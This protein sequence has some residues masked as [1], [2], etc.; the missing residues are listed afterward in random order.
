MPTNKC[1]NNTIWD[2][3]GKGAYLHDTDCRD[4]FCSGLRAFWETSPYRLKGRT[5]KGIYFN[6]LFGTGQGIKIPPNTFPVYQKYSQKE[7]VEEYAEKYGI[8]IVIKTYTPD[9]FYVFAT[10]KSADNEEHLWRRY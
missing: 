4:E 2:N 3:T 9:G 6:G 5:S 7:L 1:T 8:P 10:E